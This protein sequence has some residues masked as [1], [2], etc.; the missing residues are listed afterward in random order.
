MCNLS[1]FT[2]TS[3]APASRPQS[4]ELSDTPSSN[5]F[6]A[7][8]RAFFGSGGTT[9]SEELSRLFDE[10]Y[11]GDRLSLAKLMAA[12]R[13]F[14]FE[15]RHTLWIP[16]FQFDPR[17]LSPQPFMEKILAVLTPVCS[18]WQLANW[19]AKPHPRLG[20]RRP[21]DMVNQDLSA[22][23]AAARATRFETARMHL[24]DEGHAL[25][26]NA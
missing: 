4:D 15:W 11:C 21:V 5:G 14:V 25:S 10:R 26:A 19:F 9:R 7:L 1:T 8:I 22:V 23:L 6:L 20:N 18:G 17:D 12:E 3:A 16:M 2:P 13:V 24:V